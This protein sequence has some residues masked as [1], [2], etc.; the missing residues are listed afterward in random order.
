MATRAY[1]VP[2]GRRVICFSSSSPSS[3]SSFSSGSGMGSI[4]K[5]PALELLALELLR[6]SGDGDGGGFSFFTAGAGGPGFD[7]SG[8]S[9]IPRSSNSRF[10]SLD[11]RIFLPSRSSSLRLI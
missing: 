11:P 7:L 4:L 1:T 10:S 6:L 2:I 5:L 3:S 9:T 8:M